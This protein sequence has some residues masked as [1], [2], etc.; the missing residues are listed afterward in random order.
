M[1]PAVLANAS[2]RALGIAL[3][4][5]SSVLL[6]RLLGTEGY[7]QYALIAS[8][9]GV[10]GILAS[11]GLGPA[12]LR[13][14]ALHAAGSDR[15]RLPR[16]LRRTIRA[17]ALASL[18]AGGILL[19]LIRSSRVM[20][21]D[22]ALFALV[23]LACLPAFQAV[24][25][26]ASSLLQGFRRLI[27][28]AVP[29]NL[30]RPLLF[31]VLLLGLVF[32]EHSPDW[33]VAVGALVF[34]AGAAAVVAIIL[35]R[36]FY[37]QTPTSFSAEAL[38]ASDG[39]RRSLFAIVILQVL[40]AESVVLAAGWLTGPDE[41]GY[42]HLARRFGLLLLIPGLALHAWI[43]PRLTPLLHAGCG[44]EADRLI[45]RTSRA[46]SVAVWAGAI[47]LF[48]IARPVL[49]AVYGPDWLPVEGPLRILIFARIIDAWALCLTPIVFMGHREREAA[50][51]LAVTF[52]VVAVSALLLIP[53]FG[54]T[55]AAV[56][57]AI[58]T[59]AWNAGFTWIV[60]WRLHRRPSWLWPAREY[61][62]TGADPASS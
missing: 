34:A 40:I 35:C 23:G 10:L 26:L 52:A 58:G 55:G 44:S 47:L 9:A 3:S 42:Y 27:W 41:I 6:T 31:L 54:A 25:V 60:V 50:C 51:V 38:P 57:E 33:T 24:L 28:S 48:L 61:R 21:T 14:A 5:V 1:S 17:V 13:E 59:L 18:V 29:E 30:V 4:F 49:G 2:L 37:G 8:W 36:H 45:A 20:G 19:M 62:E 46:G 16:H 12:L 32:T 22:A 43:S 7:G 56:A 11:L 53:P 15:N 39:S